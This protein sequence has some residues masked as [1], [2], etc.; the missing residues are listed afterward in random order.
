MAQLIPPSVPDDQNFA[1]TPVLKPLFPAGRNNHYSLNLEWPAAPGKD[2]HDDEPLLTA[3]NWRLGQFTDLKPWQEFFGSTDLLQS[4]KKMDPVLD[5]I[6]TASR[7]PYSRFPI[8][9]EKGYATMIPNLGLFISLSRI[10]R[11]RHR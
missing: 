7:R 5:E 3:A 4:L 11:S 2:P 8:D 10:Y 1:M 9:Y 6:S